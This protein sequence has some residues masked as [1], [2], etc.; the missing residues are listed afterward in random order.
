MTYGRLILIILI[1]TSIFLWTH[2]NH[3]VLGICECFPTR[4]NH[5][6]CFF[7]NIWK[8]LENK[9]LLST[10]IVK[11]FFFFIFLI[12]IWSIISLFLIFPLF[13]KFKFYLRYIFLKA[14]RVFFLNY[15]LEAFSRGILR[16][17]ILP[18]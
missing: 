10:S 14:K 11:N 6:T 18:F 16:A 15:L 4:C 1:I 9:I 13:I 17:K 12:A 2:F 8:H 5:Q 3:C 7:Q